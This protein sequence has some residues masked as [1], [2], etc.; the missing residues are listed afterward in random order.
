MTLGGALFAVAVATLPLGRS[1]GLAIRG[2]DLTVIQPVVVLGDVLDLASLPPDIRA[3]AERVVLVR[4]RAGQS[5]LSFSTRSLYAR[6]RALAPALGPWTPRGDDTLVVVRRAAPGPDA[7][8]RSAA[9]SRPAISPGDHLR[10]VTVVG[11]VTIERDVEAV[12][13]AERGDD[14]FVRSSDGRVFSA[15]AEDI[16]P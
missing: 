4:F 2:Q 6:S 12:Q 14:V 16:A 15:R 11:P 9:M 10:L 7:A 3:R 5:Q 13:A 8:A 1:G